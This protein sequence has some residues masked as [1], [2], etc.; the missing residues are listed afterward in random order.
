MALL[1]RIG[2]R[3]FVCWRQESMLLQELEQVALTRRPAPQLPASQA[4]CAPIHRARLVLALLNFESGTL[5]SRL[6]NTNSGTNESSWI[7]L[8]VESDKGPTER[9]RTEVETK[10]N[11]GCFCLAVHGRISLTSKWRNVKMRAVYLSGDCSAILSKLSSNSP[12]ALCASSAGPGTCTSAVGNCG[13]S[14]T[15]TYHATV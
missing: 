3:V 8:I 14:S 2:I 5:D 7:V 10:N 4:R 11:W 9:R 13:E 6:K 15:R 1:R 12:S